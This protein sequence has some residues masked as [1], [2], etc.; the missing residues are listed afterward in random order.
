[1]VDEVIHIHDEICNFGKT[2]NIIENDHYEF[3]MYDIYVEKININN[4]YENSEN[5]RIKLL[6]D[7][8]NVNHFRQKF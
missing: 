3:D 1:M 4:L 8:M 5:R 6:I 2:I 7:H